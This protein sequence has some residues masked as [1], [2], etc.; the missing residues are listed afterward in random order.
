MLLL[1]ALILLAVALS[2]YAYIVTE[3]LEFTIPASSFTTNVSGQPVTA[4]M[5]P[6]T[7][8]VSDEA[9]SFFNIKV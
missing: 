7:F 3:G 1:V 2:G 8:K 6:A 4:S 5:A 9:I